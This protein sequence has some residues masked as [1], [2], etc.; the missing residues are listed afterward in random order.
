MRRPLISREK[1]EKGEN[2]DE[3]TPPTQHK[4]GELF[5]KL[6][7]GGK[8]HCL[9]KVSFHIARG[10]IYFKSQFERFISQNPMHVW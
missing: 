6:K 8:G 4:A 2:L 9:R 1:M 10:S 5:G 3:F 7:T